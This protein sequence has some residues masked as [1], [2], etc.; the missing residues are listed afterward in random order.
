MVSYM[1]FDGFKRVLDFNIIFL[2]TLTFFMLIQP[3]LIIALAEA[4]LGWVG[5]D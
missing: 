4:T 1:Y 5:K 2:V 3:T